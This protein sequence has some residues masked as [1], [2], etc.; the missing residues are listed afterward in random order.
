MIVGSVKKR[1]GKPKKLEQGFEMLS[2]KL[3]QLTAIY[4]QEAERNR[5]AQQ[6]LFT[7]QDTQFK[8]MRSQT[9]AIR[10]VAHSVCNGNKVRA[11]DLCDEAD[12]LCEEGEKTQSSYLIH[13]D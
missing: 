9:G 6:V 8:I 1:R 5:L 4:A 7:V 2:T 11:M 12:H 3:D 10:E 13:K